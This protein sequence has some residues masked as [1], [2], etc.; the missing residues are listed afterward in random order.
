MKNEIEEIKD[1]EPDAWLENLY[2]L[3]SSGNRSAAVDLVLYTFDDLLYARNVSMCNE[4]L[5]RVDV[6]RLLTEVSLAFLMETFRA[7]HALV[8][9][10]GLYCR[11]HD[12]F[13][14]SFPDRV[15]SLIGN[16]K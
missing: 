7:R 6:D 9:R 16:L 14:K 15:V 12:K 2:Q 10:A 3:C 13:Q 5:K 4:L 8:E 1:I 11:I